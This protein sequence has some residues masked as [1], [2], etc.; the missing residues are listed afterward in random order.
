MSA[1]PV[2]RSRP[3]VTV[4]LTGF[5]GSGKSTL[6]TALG[7]ALGERRVAHFVLDGDLVRTGLCRDL[8][9]TETDRHENIRRVAEVARLMNLAGVDVICALI[10]PQSEHRETARRIIG[11]KCFIEVHVSTPLEHCER[12]D[13][14]GLYRRARAG[15]L[16]GFTGIDAPYEVPT[17]PALRIDTSAEGLVACADRLLTLW[18]DWPR[19]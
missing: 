6:A 1:G 15:Q 19:S 13:P 11:A 17:D 7:Q 14:K 12:R 2:S 5:S 9:F 10:S 18:S 16:P 3:P 8:G 4:W